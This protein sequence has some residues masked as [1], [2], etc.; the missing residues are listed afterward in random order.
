MP[1][2]RLRVVKQLARGPPAWEQQNWAQNLFPDS[3]GWGFPGRFS[4]E[5]LSLLR[6]GSLAAWPTPR[7]LCQETSWEFPSWGVLRERRRG[8]EDP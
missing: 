8:P 4:F 7:Q 3:S 1:K 5:V 2:L 6:V